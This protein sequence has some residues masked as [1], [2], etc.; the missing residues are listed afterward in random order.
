MKVLDEIKKN[1]DWLDI[2]A[3]TPNITDISIV[4]VKLSTQGV[5]LGEL[6]S[7]AYDVMVDL[8]EEY[9]SAMAE[10]VNQLIREGMGV[11]AAERQAEE[12]LKQKRKDWKDADK[13]FSRLRGFLDRIDKVSDAV[14]QRVSV[15]KQTGLKGMVGT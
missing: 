6:K 7:D 2:N 3:K 12:F 13:I 15:E 14:R 5:T 1:I 4:L 11:A 9:K 10:K 8:E